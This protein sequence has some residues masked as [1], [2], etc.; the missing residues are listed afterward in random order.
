MCGLEFS[1]AACFCQGCQGLRESFVV[2]LGHLLSSLGPCCMEPG[3]VTELEK[4]T[5]KPMCSDSVIP[6]SLRAGSVPALFDK[7]PVPSTS[8]NI[9]WGEVE[10]ITLYFGSSQTCLPKATH[11]TGHGE[12]D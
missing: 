3:W 8:Q 1:R 5:L 7:G 6:S 4:A 11:Q 9:L 2:C 10:K 12:R